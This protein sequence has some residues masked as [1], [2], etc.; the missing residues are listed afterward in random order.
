[1]VEPKPA[2]TFRILVF[3]SS[4]SMAY[5][6]NE[7]DGYVRLFEAWARRITPSRRT[8]EVVNLAIAGDS[9][10]RRLYRLQLEAHRLQPD[11]I[12]FDASAFDGFLEASH[13]HA[14][15]ERGLPIPYPFL[16]EVIDRCQLSPADTPDSIRHK[17][18]PEP[19]GLLDATYAIL[20]DEVHKLG[21]P[22]EIIIL[23][24]ADSQRGFPAI[25]QAIHTAGARHGLE[26][27]D[28]S[29]A[30]DGLEESEFRLSAWD[31][32]PSVRGHR[33]IFEALRDALILRNQLPGMP[34]T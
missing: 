20:A 23:P 31:K 16:R 34:T 14:V 21:V 11:R 7:E 17:L 6:I 2:G 8:I 18:G 33:A 5:G 30:F 28:L 25:L 4:N 22:F 19:D 32:H 29:D 3:G 12:F 9:P 27:I 1:V 26:I 10:S 24:R 15:H 13:L